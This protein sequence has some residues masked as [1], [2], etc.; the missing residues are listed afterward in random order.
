MQAFVR[1]PFTLRWIDLPADRRLRRR[2]S[3]IR[4]IEIL[5]PALLASCTTVRNPDVCCTSDSE[6]A[7]LGLPPGSVSEYGSCG[8]GRVCR[9]FYCV[10]PPVPIVDNGQPA[11]LVLG[12]ETF[13]WA[14]QN[15]GGISAR[16]LYWPTGVAVDEAGR[17]WVLDAGNCRALMWNPAPA[18]S[19]AEAAQVVGSADFTSTSCSCTGSR[20]SVG[21]LGAPAAHG[22]KLLI[23]AAGCNHV[24]VWNPAPTA[25]GAEASTALGQGSFYDSLPGNGAGDFDMPAGVWTD[26]T[27][28]VVADAQNNRVL[29]WT[30]FPRTNKAPAN[31][32]LGQQGFGTSGLPPTPTGATMRSPSFVYSD[33]VRLFVSDAEN[34]RVLVWHSFPTTSGQPADLAIG[35][36]DLTSDGIGHGGSQLWLPMGVA[37]AGDHLFVADHNNYRVLVFSPIPTA[38]GVHASFVLGQLDFETTNQV[39][40]QETLAGPSGLAVDGNK[41]YVADIRH[42]RV[43]RFALRL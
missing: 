34:N 28:V 22:G 4:W 19:F 26:G 25:N 1:P 32:V 38:S 14:E 15:Y 2:G 21:S 7:Y 5:L 23:P 13:T 6:C 16:S 39:A 37:V 24:K 30:S 17:L 8:E 11:E 9:E 35:Q 12:Q 20:G 41:L 40:T 10:E 31:I 29:I 27:R 3:R 18:T 43:L 33:G 42:N 36:P